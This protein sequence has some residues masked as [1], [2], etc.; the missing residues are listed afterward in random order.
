MQNIYALCR[1]GRGRI[2]AGTD[3]HGLIVFNRRKW[4]VYDRLNGPRGERIFS[5]ACPPKNGDIAVAHS[6]GIAVYLDSFKRWVHLS[7]LS[8]LPSNQAESLT[9][10]SGGTLWEGF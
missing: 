8:G 2:W 1:D 10:S 9:F 6:A 5:I 4:K 3:Q 7:K